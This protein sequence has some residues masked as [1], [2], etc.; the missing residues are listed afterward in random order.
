M[1]YATN[2][3]L[4]QRVTPAEL[5]QLTC[6]D[7]TK[8]LD[9]TKVDAAIAE[10][11]GKVEGY[12]RARYVTPL[13]TSQEVTAIVRDIAIYLLFSRRPQKMRDTVRQ[14]YED[15]ISLLKDVS[16]GKASLDQP[17][18]AAIPQS[19]TGGPVLPKRNGLRFTDRKLEGFV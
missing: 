10:A 7:D 5:V 15:A 4:L 13:Q 12:C 9:Q 2:A 19:S 1:A 18:G 14:L 11:S 17:V 16:T 6:D 3:D 8:T